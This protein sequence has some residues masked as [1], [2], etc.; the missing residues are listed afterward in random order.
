MEMGERRERPLSLP[1]PW[2]SR[3]RLPARLVRRV[4]TLAT[5]LEPTVGD[6]LGGAPLLVDSRAHAGVPPVRRRGAGGVHGGGALR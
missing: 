2:R 1:D 4:P 3:C 5:R 6:H